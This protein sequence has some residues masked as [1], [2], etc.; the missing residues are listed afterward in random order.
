[1][2]LDVWCLTAGCHI[3][4]PSQI[5][6]NLCTSLV[7]VQILMRA[8]RWLFFFPPLASSYVWQRRAMR[9]TSVHV[10]ILC[11][12]LHVHTHLCFAHKHIWLGL[13][14]SARS[15]CVWPCA[16]VS[17][18]MS[19]RVCMC[20]CLPCSK[21]IHLGGRWL[22]VANGRL[23]RWVHC[24]TLAAV[25]SAQV[26]ASPAQWRCQCWWVAGG[27]T[28]LFWWQNDSAVRFTTSLAAF[29]FVSLYWEASVVP[30]S[31]THTL[32]R[33]YSLCESTVY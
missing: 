16:L 4:I 19:L 2:T 30:W 24:S 27:L 25:A 18:C 22:R 15:V 32:P 13:F 17:V 26:T 29:R 8:F 31:P 21:V 28:T 9:Y 10:C 11:I 23:D 14:V 1:M 20:V 3:V 33:L 7:T 6:P 12:S 5:S